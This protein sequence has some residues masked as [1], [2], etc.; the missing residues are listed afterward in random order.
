VYALLNSVEYRLF[1]C[2]RGHTV[3]DLHCVLYVVILMFTATNTRDSA[4][5]KIWS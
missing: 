4:S 1:V 5:G 3:T 2:R